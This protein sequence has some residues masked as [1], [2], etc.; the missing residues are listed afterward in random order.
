[1]RAVCY[2]QYG[3]PEVLHLETVPD[4][5][6]PGERDILVRV[7]AAEVTKGDCE[8]RAFRLPVKWTWL[9]LRLAM[10]VTRPRKPIL[11]CY[12]AGEVVAVGRGVQRFKEGDRV[13][14]SAGFQ[15]GAHAELLCL[16]ETRTLVPMPAN[17]S[18]AEAAAVPLGG[19]NALHFLRRAKIQPGEKVLVNGAGGSIGAFGV[20]IAR[21]MGAGVTAVDAAHKEAMVRGLGAE[22]FI[23]YR[24]TDFTRSGRTYDVILSTVASSSYARC[25]RVLNP[26]GRYLIANPR[27]SDLMRSALPS[28]FGDRESIVAF[29]AETNEELTALGAL[30]EAGSIRAAV[31]RVYPMAAAAEAHRRVET[32]ARLGA[33][34]LSMDDRAEDSDTQQTLR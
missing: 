17:L 3:P 8:L 6:A 29:A 20:Q 19:L 14:G 30:L 33:V 11:G 18:F 9:P 34:V 13:F 26:G 32:E 25:M 2:R 21:H 5:P 31:D 12:F 28:R 23:D 4:P 10:G 15:F 27:M 24:K 7:R 1:M 16:P 22:H